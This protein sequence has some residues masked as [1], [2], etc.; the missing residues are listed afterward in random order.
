MVSSTSPA[1]EGYS[2]SQ[3]ALHWTI[4]ALV[5]VQ[6]FSHEAMEHAFDAQEKGTGQ[7]TGDPVALV[8]AGSGVVIL[9]LMAV[10]LLLRARL[11]A[12]ALPADMPDALKLGAKISHHA[13]YTLLFLI[14]VAGGLAVVL[15]SET[16]AGLHGLLLILLW[17]VLFL[18]VGGA[19]YHALVRRDGVFQRML[20]PG[21]RR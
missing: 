16:A 15:T 9:V 13:L 12:P 21:P 8:H 5:L 18:H 7:V 1:S 17:I 3:I 4:V 19:L 20:L 14:P 11:G 2:A 6:L 10:R